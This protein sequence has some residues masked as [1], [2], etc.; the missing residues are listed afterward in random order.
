MALADYALAGRPG[1][2]TY[3]QK[4]QI[5][6]LTG[7][8]F[9]TYSGLN[10]PGMSSAGAGGKGGSQVAGGTAAGGSASNAFDYGAYLLQLQA[11]QQAAR[12]AAY[13]VAA[14]Q[15]KTNYNYAQGQL[16]DSTGAALREAY[17]NKMLTLK[18]MPQSLSAQGLHGGMSETTTGSMY[19]SYANARNSLETERQ[20]QLAALLNTY[21]NNMAQLESERAGGTAASLAQL[22]PQLIKLAASNGVNL[23]SLVQATGEIARRNVSA[24]DLQAM[25]QI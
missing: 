21:Q 13:N 18:N 10:K 17:I 9:H 12:N 20:N 2:I 11:Q 16:N 19:N 6:K 8:Q 14:N 22:T 7:Q 5:D 25:Y 1:A 3:E 15:Q 23:L 4:K 24:E